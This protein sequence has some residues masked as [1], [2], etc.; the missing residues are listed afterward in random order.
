MHGEGDR[1]PYPFLETDHNEFGGWFSP[2]GKWVLYI[3][4]ESGLSQAYVMPFPG[5]GP[6]R[7][8]SNDSAVW[9]WWRTSSEVLLLSPSGT[10]Y[11]V[12]VD[13]SK[14][15]FRTGAAQNWIDLRPV[16]VGEPSH[17]GKRFIAAVLPDD[18]RESEFTLLVNWA[19]GLDQP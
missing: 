14:G 17:D 4:D 2:D 16:V 15:G 5:P 12:E 18:R 9:G 3:S 6:K 19:Q 11:A 8:V 13:I 1:E 10:V 7:H